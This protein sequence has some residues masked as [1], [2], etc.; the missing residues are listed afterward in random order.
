MIASGTTADL[1]KG[2]L[3]IESNCPLKPK[4][5]QDEMLLSAY[6]L[7]ASYSSRISQLTNPTSSVDQHFDPH[8]ISST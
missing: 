1:K 5:G 4:K 7:T 6:S 8:L 2:F 3:A